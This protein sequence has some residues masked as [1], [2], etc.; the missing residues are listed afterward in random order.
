M[1]IIRKFMTKISK[2]S[3]IWQ[4]FS[5]ACNPGTNLV[6]DPQKSLEEPEVSHVTNPNSVNTSFHW[7]TSSKIEPHVQKVM[8][9]GVTA[10]NHPFSLNNLEVV[11]RITKE[12]YL[13]DNCIKIARFHARKEGNRISKGRVL[14]P[15]SSDDAEN[16]CWNFKLIKVQLLLP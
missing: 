1:D 16:F 4:G 7:Q 5:T 8:I 12:F 2:R 15:T 3:N 9:F 10:K 6:K 11:V 13:F 14:W